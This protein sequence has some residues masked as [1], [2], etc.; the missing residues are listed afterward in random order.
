MGLLRLGLDLPCLHPEA[1]AQMQIQ[2]PQSSQFS[3]VGQSSWTKYL[4]FVLLGWLGA[5]M[6]LDFVVMPSLYLTGMMTSTDFA[7]AGYVLFGVFNHAEVLAG[8]A[9][10][11][12]LLVLLSE[13]ALQSYSRA[14]TAIQ[15]LTLMTIALFYTYCLTPAM[16]A[17]VLSLDGSQLVEVT[18]AM[19]I[20]Q[21][22][23]WALEA[24]K[25]TVLVLLV[26]RLSTVVFPV[27][28]E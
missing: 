4:L 3:R 16:S 14:A 24:I 17:L 21:A 28:Q 13:G 5:T 11:T 8:A 25:L 10:L 19:N 6:V 9:V 12:G 7:G 1:I 15:G 20:L 18:R 27:G 2:F 26:R 23:Y 22:E